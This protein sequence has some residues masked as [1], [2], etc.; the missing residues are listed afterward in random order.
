M[1]AG[2]G[3]LAATRVAAEE[4]L[5]QFLPKAGRRYAD[6][7]NYDHGPGSRDN[8][9]RLSAFLRHRL[10]LEHD[11]LSSVLAQH[12]WPRP[13][14]FVQEVFWRAYFKGWLEHRPAV[15]TDYLADIR[16]LADRL[17]H[18]RAL[19]ERYR[20]AIE[21]RTGIDCFDAW[22][23]ELRD[24]GYLHNHA[25]MWFASIWLYTLQL[26]WQLG[27]DFF[28]QHLVDGDPAS[29]TLSWRWV[30]GLHTR[31]KTYLAR[32]SNIARYTDGRFNPVGQLAEE[33]PPLDDSREYGVKPLPTVPSFAFDRP[34]ALVITAEDCSPET[35]TLDTPPA[36]VVALT[37]TPS[38]SPLGECQRHV[39]FAAAAL[40]D[41]AARAQTAFDVP[42]AFA[43]SDDWL[44]AL[45]GAASA[46]G[47]D[48]FVTAAA[49]V[50][51]VATRLAQLAPDLAANGLQLIQL[52]REYDEA[53]WPHATRGFFK[54]KKQIPEVLRLIGAV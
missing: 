19:D 39:D 31:G 35:L 51:P 24:T 36:A 54:L 7:R 43:D 14:K 27:A 22:C 37:A 17:A 45:T 46:H 29:N 28:L 20:Q 21:G 3:E 11:V 49:P 4:A 53:S 6:R 52:R 50:G 15:W 34:Y 23:H 12:P 2:A 48:T 33:A 25:R 18:E 41:A 26:P 5:A 13:E 40:T 30:G 32:P 8:V 44:A 42:C 10:L 1:T 47:I 9:S 38:P 16:G